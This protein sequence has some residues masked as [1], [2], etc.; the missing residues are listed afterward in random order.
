MNMG[1]NVG[2][3]V[4]GSQ[5]CFVAAD[6]SHGGEYVEGLGAG[7]ARCDVEAERRDVCFQQPF[8]HFAVDQGVELPHQNL[9]GGK[10][11]NSLSRQW[12]DAGEHVCVFQNGVGVGDQRTL[13]LKIGVAETGAR[14]S[15]ALYHYFVKT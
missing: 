12:M 7:A 4:G 13:G 11:G 5:H 6:G 8:Y 3:V 2:Q 14:A 9:S 10:F 15:A 1:K